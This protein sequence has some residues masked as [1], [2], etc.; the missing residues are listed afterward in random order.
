MAKGSWRAVCVGSLV[1]VI[2]GVV[3]VAEGYIL[4]VRYFLGMYAKQRRSLTRLKIAQTTTT[5]RK[6]AATTVE[7]R[8]YIRVPA[9]VRLERW[10]GG[11]RVKVDIW[12]GKT[13]L[14]WRPGAAPKTAK[15]RVQRR[16]DLFAIEPTGSGFGS[17][18]AL[19]RMMRIRTRGA[20]KYSRH[21]DY[22]EQ[23]HVRLAWFQHAPAVAMGKRNQIWFHKKKVYPVRLLA[24][25]TKAGAKYD[26]RFY[27]Y[28]YQA[29]TPVF[30][31]RIELY[32]NGKKTAQTLVYRVQTGVSVPQSLFSRVK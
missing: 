26:L 31:G 16:F 30:P 22:R 12:R 5:W 3:G 10:R 25:V 4:P 6:G 21:T 24:G 18:R 9:Q 32:R 7:E 13:H 11:K 8:L 29:G 28:Y 15:R 23:H 17:I 19:L 20:T 27:D 14:Q 1:L 2:C